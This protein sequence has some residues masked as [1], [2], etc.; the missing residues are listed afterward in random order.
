[1]NV[2]EEDEPELLWGLRGAGTNFGVVTELVLAL[3]EVDPLA[4]V[5]LF[6]W[7]PED[8]A[9]PLAFARDYLFD[10]TPEMG[11]LIVGVSAPPEPF[12]P[13]EHRGIPG[14]A[15][16]VA[17]WGSAE[18]HAAAVAPLRDLGVRCSSS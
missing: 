15:V 10:L 8:A 12:V 18:E 17:S 9:G 4:N 2:S 11:A 14:I 1:M 7:R 6:F 3:H 16:V 13:V 5:G